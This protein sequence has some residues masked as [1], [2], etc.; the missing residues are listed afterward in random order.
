M[1]QMG[2][3]ECYHYTCSATESSNIHE[4]YQLIQYIEEM[5]ALLFLDYKNSF[6]FFWPHG[7]IDMKNH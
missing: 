1:Q 5:D 4:M 2:R 7:S 3:D 6:S